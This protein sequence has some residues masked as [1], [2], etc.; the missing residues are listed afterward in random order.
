MYER[1]EMFAKHSSN[2][3]CE[4]TD[5]DYLLSVAIFMEKYD[6]NDVTKWARPNLVVK[7]PNWKKKLRY[8]AR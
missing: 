1:Q 2:K 4:F 6:N 7:E 8:L 5:S 3:H